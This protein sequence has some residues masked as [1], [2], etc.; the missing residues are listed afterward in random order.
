M[1]PA[2]AS[3]KSNERKVFSNLYGDDIYGKISKPKYKL[4][5]IVRI[6]KKKTIFDKGYT[7]RWTEEVFSISQVQYTDPPTY[8]ITDTNGEEVRGTFY[9]Q[10]L[11]K[12][13]QEI[14]RIE[15][16]IKT[17][18]NKSLVKWFGYPDS[19]N[20]WVDNKDLIKI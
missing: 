9:E 5:D 4:G 16:V 14:F 1:T 3:K 15:K 2:E 18:G 12:T 6:A 11:Q 7:P 13:T 20:S 19:F 8:T 17:R 10:E